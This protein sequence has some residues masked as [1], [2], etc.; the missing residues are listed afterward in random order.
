MFQCSHYSN[1]YNVHI[2]VTVYSKLQFELTD[3]YMYIIHT[4]MYL[5][6]PETCSSGSFELF[7]RSY[8][9][10]LYR[11]FRQNR[12]RHLVNACVPLCR[13]RLEPVF[14]NVL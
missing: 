2:S 11:H 7:Q 13:F 5:C 9:H 6:F 12:I 1:E 3:A 10:A 8:I 4:Y 14:L